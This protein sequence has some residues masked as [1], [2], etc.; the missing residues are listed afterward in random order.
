MSLAG[1]AKSFGVSVEDVVRFV[2]EGLASHSVLISEI[3]SRYPSF[4][5][6]DVLH[7][8]FHLASFGSH[9]I[10]E[11]FKVLKVD[12]GF[13]LTDYGFSLDGYFWARFE[14]TEDCKLWIDTFD[15]EKEKGIISVTTYTT[16]DLSRQSRGALKKLERIVEDHDFTLPEAFYDLD[17]YEVRIPERE[18][19]FWTLEISYS[20]PEIYAESLPNLKQVSRLVRQIFRKTG[21]HYG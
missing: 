6:K 5:L 17:E 9:I 15:V 7:E 19:E 14:A 16:I 1:M 21:I 10:K 20:D 18:E 3:R 12:G 2:S 11:V 8:V 4:N 13:V